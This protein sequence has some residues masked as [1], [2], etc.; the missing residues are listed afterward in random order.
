[1]KNGELRVTTPQRSGTSSRRRFE[2]DG[3]QVSKGQDVDHTT[4]LQLGGADKTSNMSAL[5]SSVNRSL[6]AQIQQQTKG[7]PK[8]TSICGVRITDPCGK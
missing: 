1:A 7:L 8:N 4:D 3:G 6:G 5:D 2:T